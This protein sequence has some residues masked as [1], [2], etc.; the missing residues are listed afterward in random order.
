MCKE[1]GIPYKSPHK[2]RHG[3]AIFG[4]KHA[5]TMEDMKA[6]SLNLMHSSITITDS[7][8]TKLNAEGINTTI[9]RMV[10]GDTQAQATEEKEIHVRQEDLEAA[11]LKV[12]RNNPDLVREMQQPLSQHDDMVDLWKRK[13]LYQNSGAKDKK[14]LI[15]PGADHNDIM[16]VNQSLYFDT[17]EEFI[18]ACMAE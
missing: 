8:Y 13:E 12:L 14:I 18:K 6:V 9:T 17:V 11:L 7:I 4:L 15:I 3:H 16:V 10:R 2:L 5:N 1:V